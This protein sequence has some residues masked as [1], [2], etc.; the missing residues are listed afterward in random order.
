MARWKPDARQRLVVEA[1]TLFA[2]QGYDETTVAQI[3]ERAGLTRSTFHRHFA[4][5]RDILSAGHETLSR[6]LAEG[7]AEAPA[8]AAPL[9]AVAA[10]LDRASSSMTTFNRELSHLIEAAIAA[11]DEL[12]G[13]NA[14][15][16]V[17]MSAAMDDALV[18]R[19]VAAPVAR[20]AA[21]MG[22][23]A[24][25]T[26]FQRWVDPAVDDAP[27][28]LRDRTAA[29]FAELRAAAAMLADG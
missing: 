17:G 1:L 2:E 22:V 6:L 14:M 15:K 7:V 23:V 20:L 8:D 5:K 26:G 16:A 21:E 3:A 12:R 28:E 25:S 19:G 9:D 13:R 4:D 29:A 18:A 24:F 27:G 10:G 11:N